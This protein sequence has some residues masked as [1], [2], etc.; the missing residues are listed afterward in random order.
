[1]HHCSSFMP[2]APPALDYVGYV[3]KTA[4]K[5][6]GAV[7]NAMLAKLYPNTAKGKDEMESYAKWMKNNGYLK[8]VNEGPASDN[9]VVSIDAL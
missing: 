7:Y 3:Y 8:E 4:N 1:M 2:D 9:P 5:K 6:T